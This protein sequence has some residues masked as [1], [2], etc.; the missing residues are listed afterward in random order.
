MNTATAA[1]PKVLSRSMNLYLQTP[2][3]RLPRLRFSGDRNDHR[4]L[5]LPPMASRS[6]ATQTVSVRGEASPDN[7][8]NICSER[9]TIFYNEIASLL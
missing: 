3:D 8:A 2:K 1:A 9:W 5:S 4:R 6:I 7:W